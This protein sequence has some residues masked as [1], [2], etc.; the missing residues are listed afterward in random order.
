MGDRASD[1]AQLL[2][3]AHGRRVKRAGRSGV[4]LQF[5]E[6]K[7]RD[8]L[9][10]VEDSLSGDGNSFENRLVLHHEAGG[11]RLDA[12]QLLGVGGWPR[13]GCRSAVRGAAWFDV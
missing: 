8:F 5:V 6:H 7:L 4:F 3:V 9:Q 2:G 1:V 10:R 13:S 11:Q 12:A